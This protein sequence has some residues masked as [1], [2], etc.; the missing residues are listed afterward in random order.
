[1]FNVSIHAPVRGATKFE[2]GKVVVVKFQSTPL[3]EGRRQLANVPIEYNEF[4]STPLCE[5]RRPDPVRAGG[6]PQFQ[7]TPLCEGRHSACFC[8]L[9]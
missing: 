4:Q 2:A 3:C 9:G 5:G 8:R 6:G 7:S 1:V